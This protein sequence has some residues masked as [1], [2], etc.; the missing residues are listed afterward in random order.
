MVC[1]EWL[2][3]VGGGCAFG[4]QRNMLAGSAIVFGF[5]QHD[6]KAKEWETG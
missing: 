5:D 1:A 3:V 4:I 2:E 6:R